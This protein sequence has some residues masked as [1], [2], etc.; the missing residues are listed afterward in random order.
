MHARHH[1]L[2]PIVLHPDE[3]GELLGCSGW[4]IRRLIKK[5]HL[6]AIRIGRR[7]LVRTDDVYALLNPARGTT[8][9]I[10]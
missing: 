2:T 10:T 9:Q 8:A 3:V 1:S 5:G 4:T 6:P 7:Y